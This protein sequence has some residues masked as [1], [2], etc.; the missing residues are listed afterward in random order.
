MI[1]FINPRISD[2]MITSRMYA[3]LL[4][5]VMLMI[6]SFHPTIYA[7]GSNN[8]TKENVGNLTGIWKKN[9][10]NYVYIS[11][12]ESDIS[13]IP[14]QEGICNIEE[15][16]QPRVIPIRNDFNA[17]IE[18]NRVLGTLSMCYT[19]NTDSEKNGVFLDPFE[20]EVND[21]NTILEG[22]VK[23]KTG[24]VKEL[25]YSKIPI[26]L[27]VDT[28][29]IYNT[30]EIVNISGIVDGVRSISDQKVIMTIY[31]KN[32]NP[33]I[34]DIVPIDTDTG[35][36]E[37]AIPKM[38][39]SDYQAVFSYGGS[40]E[41][42]FFVVKSE[43]EKTALITVG[44][45]TGGAVV[46]SLLLYSRLE[47]IKGPSIGSQDPSIT[48]MNIEPI[49]G[50][51]KNTI[52]A[53]DKLMN[54]PPIPGEISEIKEWII[55]ALDTVLKNRNN[56]HTIK[57]NAATYK[58]FIEWSSKTNKNIDS[59]FSRISNKLIESLVN[60]VSSY[61]ANFL[62]NELI[63]ETELDVTETEKKNIKL[64][65]YFSLIPINYYIGF[66]T[67]FNGITS[68]SAKIIMTI[69]SQFNSNRITITE[70]KTNEVKMITV[71]NPEIRI[72]ISV[73]GITFDNR[74]TKHFVAVD[75]PV[76]LTM[77]SLQ[78]TKFTFTSLN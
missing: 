74:I 6:V 38:D 43:F 49:F 12:K 63:I 3:L 75:P 34:K 5:M 8:I 72:K 78:K 26:N 15:E 7:Q 46:G 40:I 22:I 39:P 67:S 54:R 50:I 62:L 19:G 57:E 4:L 51:E 56:I 18:E 11:H 68:G 58:E 10:D 13:S 52:D 30:N 66:V 48:N 37:Y 36:F 1:H 25:L 60:Q 27:I 64:N 71:D 31:N 35:F 59:I 77:F 61:L 24:Q 65:I 2:M 42:K 70:T 47:M 29:P 32:Q 73:T 14:I 23:Y 76:L 20:I 16:E 9:N 17:T 21:N 53:N 55:P 44:S 69:D 45:I 33:I 41:E 28:D